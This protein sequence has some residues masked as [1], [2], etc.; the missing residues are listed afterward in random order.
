MDF[1]PRARTRTNAPKGSEKRSV[2]NN[3]NGDFG[4]VY[5]PAPSAVEDKIE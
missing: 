2:Y 4:K 1:G 5:E 3:K